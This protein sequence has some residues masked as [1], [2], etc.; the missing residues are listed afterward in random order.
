MNKPP[1]RSKAAMMFMTAPIFFIG[2]LLVA[3]GVLIVLV[4]IG[5]T[6]N[7]SKV[8]VQYSGECVAASEPIIS[9][10]AEEIGLG[11]P[12][13]SVQE[14]RLL[15][16]AVLPNSTEAES[17]IPDLLVQRGILTV[18][19]GDEW[20]SQPIEIKSASIAH[21]ES[22]MPYTKLVLEESFKKN[23]QKRILAEPKGSLQFYLDGKQIISRPNTALLADEELRLIWAK[24]GK[25]ERY[26]HSA[27]WSIVL[28][29]G[30]VPCALKIDKIK[31]IS[32]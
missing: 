25:K 2:G 19:D 12:K 24:G 16:E 10:R 21:D 26:L 1:P 32:G 15:V 17:L 31:K 30:P 6:A 23:L 11:T 14:G 22:G 29:H 5:N 4:W 27:N 7:G 28:K 9:A 3:V 13:I 8:Q 18:A 20:V